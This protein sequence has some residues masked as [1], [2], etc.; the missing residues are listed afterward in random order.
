MRQALVHLEMPEADLARLK[1]RFPQIQFTV[2]TDREKVLDHLKDTEILLI[3][4]LCTQRMLAAAPKLK[5]V[6][7]ISAGVD[8]IAMDEI[9]R[10]AIV[11][12]NGRGIHKIHMAEYTIAA[13]VHL[14]RNFHALFRNQ[15]EKKWDRTVSQGEISGATV[16]ILGLG[17]IGSEIAKKASLMGMRVIGVQRTP[18]PHTCVEAVYGP[19]DIR[20]VFEESDYVVNL[21]P[22]TPV[23]ERL[24][25]RRLFALMKPDACFINIGRGKTVNEADLAEA[26]KNK[27]L[28][29]AVSD[30]FYEEPL[31]AE[32]PL[33]ELDNL[34]ITPHVCGVSPK[35][36]ERAMAIIE[37]N[38]DVYVSGKGRMV[39]VVD[40][41]LGY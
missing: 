37:H 7:A 35:Y 23:T 1:T 6:Q 8:Y 41:A 3:F 30:V 4:F 36:M 29:A 22:H 33:W 25:D 14:A 28:R 32:N 18:R 13:M 9:R 19:E 27:T 17:A 34:F 26:L 15:M 2:C 40:P 16:G 39:N 31:P 38:L 24:I 11:V 20:R 12:T 5:W 21:L 10:R